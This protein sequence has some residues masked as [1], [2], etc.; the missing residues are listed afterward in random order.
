MVGKKG[1]W[2]TQKIICRYDFE[3]LFILGMGRLL[4]SMEQY[5]TLEYENKIK[6][7]IYL[8]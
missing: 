8:I 4:R 3:N 6:M 2:V 1:R 7:C 5:T